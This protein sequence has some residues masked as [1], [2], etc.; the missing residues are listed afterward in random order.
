MTRYG[1]L[2]VAK[3][4][5]QWW[6]PPLVSVESKSSHVKFI[7]VRMS[8]NK[9][10]CVAKQLWSNNK[11]IKQS[12]S[13]LK[14]KHS[15]QKYTLRQKSTQNSY[16]QQRRHIPYLSTQSLISPR[17]YWSY[18]NDKKPVSN[19]VLLKIHSFKNN[20]ITV[21]HYSL[22]WVCNNCMFG[23]SV[24]VYYVHNWYQLNLYVVGTWYIQKGLSYCWY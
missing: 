11:Y 8:E 21:Y 4:S 7:A 17:R 3:Q 18:A 9:Y 2:L 12:A 14:E 22:H 24:M 5:Q 13:P 15:R 10:C 6:T 19:N 1:L 20:E 23:K 16:I